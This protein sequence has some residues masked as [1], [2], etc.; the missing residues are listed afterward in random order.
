VNK[1]WH[2]PF[3]CFLL[4]SCHRQPNHSKKKGQEVSDTVA[5]FIEKTK[6]L[7]TT[8]EEQDSVTSTNNLNLISDKKTEEKTTPFNKSKRAQT[9]TADIW[10][11]E[12]IT[13]LNE[14]EKILVFHVRITDI[15]SRKLDLDSQLSKTDR[16]AF[17]KVLL[18]PDSYANTALIKPKKGKE[19][20]PRYQVLLEAGDEKLTLIFDIL[21]LEMVVASL[22]DRKHYKI[23]SDLVDFVVKLQMKK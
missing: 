15:G 7:E 3:I 21:N 16:E 13:F 10:T 18:D 12:Q 6:R 1:C 9:V 14:I 8:F 11:E 22:F 20:K 23:T 5:L 2:I 4:I 17:V 19:F